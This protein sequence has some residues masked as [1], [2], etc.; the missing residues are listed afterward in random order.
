MKYLRNKLGITQQELANYLQVQRSILTRHEGGNKRMSYEATQKLHRLEIAVNRKP[1]NNKLS[2][3]ATESI[4]KL[5]ETTGKKLKREKNSLL[6]KLVKTE[7]ALKNAKNTYKDALQALALISHLQQELITEEDPDNKHL[8]YM[9]EKKALKKL[10]VYNPAMQTILEARLKGYQ[11]MI[12][13]MNE[14]E[15]NT[16]DK[17]MCADN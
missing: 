12:A 3:A 6:I 9:T 8:L 15:A 13:A 16:S 1:P 5:A 7:R 10:Q 11:A 14:N 4:K 2:P 17:S